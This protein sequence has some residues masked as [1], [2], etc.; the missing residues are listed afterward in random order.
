MARRR[1]HWH[2]GRDVLLFTIGVIGILHE[3]VFTSLDRPGVLAL[4]AVLVGVPT[5]LW[6]DGPER[7]GA[8]HAA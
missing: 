8:S 1:R 7:N 6:F 2:I 3:V 5:Y 4:M